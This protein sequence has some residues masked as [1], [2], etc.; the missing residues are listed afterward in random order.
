MRSFITIFFSFLLF[1]SC[2]SQK[3]GGAGSSVNQT[4][5]DTAG[6]TELAGISTESRLKEAPFGKWY[7]ANY[8][9]YSPDND[10]ALQL[11]PLLKGKKIRI[12]M[13]TWCGDSRLQ[14]PRMFRVLHQC[15]V[16]ASSI[17]L[18]CT[19]R[20]DSTY[21]Q[22]PTHEERGR[23][24]FRVPTLIVY[25]KGKETGRIIESPVQSIEKDLL[26]ICRREKYIPLYPAAGY[27][28]NWYVN[29]QWPQRRSD[30]TELAAILKPLAR[31]AGELSSL[32]RVQL[33]AGETDKAVFTLQLNSMLYPADPALWKLLGNTLLRTG[34]TARARA[35]FQKMETLPKQ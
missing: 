23:D 14:V 15:G 22:S 20:T 8:E 32:S 25:E 6:N 31:Y 27:L 34:D 19:G 13:G 18:V 26:A 1:I 21:K 24:I 17:E 9:G 10:I 2:T 35:A 5:T 12:F 16:P 30:S 11:T 28:I 29:D 7:N 33:L 3:S 4:I